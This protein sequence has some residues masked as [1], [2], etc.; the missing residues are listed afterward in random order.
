MD[1]SMVVREA[2]PLDAQAIF[3]L[4]NHP[5]IRKASF[6]HSPINWKEHLRWF[7][8]VRGDPRCGFYVLEI[9][10]ALAG[11][12]RFSLEGARATVS[13]S[14]DP[15]YRGRGVG[16][17]LYRQGLAAFEVRYRVKEIVAKIKKLNM[18]SFAFFKGLG[19]AFDSEEC[20]NGQEAVVMVSKLA[21]PE[22]AS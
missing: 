20:I 17:C 2:G 12:I 6:N 11:Q 4:S 22:V 14:V 15:R 21:S 19:F 3:K 7:K 16:T 1:D 10:G 5:S 13:I 8:R 9:G 18:E